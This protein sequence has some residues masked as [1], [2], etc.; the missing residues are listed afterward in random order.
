MLK[1]I[2]LSDLRNYESKTFEFS[3]GVTVVAGEICKKCGEKIK[4]MK[5]GGRCTFYCPVCQK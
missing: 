2:S 3:D 1:N 4:K 5:I